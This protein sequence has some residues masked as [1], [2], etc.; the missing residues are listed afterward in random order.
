MVSGEAQAARVAFSTT[1]SGWS[2]PYFSLAGV[3]GVYK[4]SLFGRSAASSSAAVFFAGARGARG[5]RI[6]RPSG[7]G[8][9]RGGGRGANGAL[10]HEGCQH[11]HHVDAV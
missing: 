8:H 5:G 9:H 4:M 1:G 3:Y 2:R 10:L 11:G 6:E 7:C